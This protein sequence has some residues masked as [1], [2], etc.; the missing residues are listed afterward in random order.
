MPASLGG[1]SEDL[2]DV[3]D[4]SMTLIAAASKCFPSTGPFEVHDDSDFT[5]F[6]WPD[7]SNVSAQQS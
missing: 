5:A 3:D 2:R 7:T 6:D 1:L 4:N